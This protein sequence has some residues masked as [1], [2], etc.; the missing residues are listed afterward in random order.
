[1]AKS[2]SDTGIRNLK[3]RAK[4]YMVGDGA[5]LWLR[6]RTSGSK[7]FIVRKKTAGK[8]KNFT[9]GTWPDLSLLD[10]RRKALDPATTAPRQAVT[11]AELCDEFYDSEI[12]PKY[13]RPHHVRGYLDKLVDELGKRRLD[14][15]TTR[16]VSDF[17][18][19]YAKHGKV[20]ANRLL[21]IARQA[22]GYGVESGYIKVNP[23]DGL[24]RRVAGGEETTRARV[25]TDEEIRALWRVPSPHGPLLRFLTLTAARIGE[26]QLAAPA[27]VMGD[28]W[29]IPA[30]H[31]K[32]GRPHDVPLSAQAKAELATLP[33]D[34]RLLFG[35]TTTTG[36]QAWLRRWCEKK[37]I[38]PRFTPHDLRR[39]AATRMSKL[40]ILPHVIE[41]AL[42][43]TMQGVMGIYNRADFMEERKLALALWGAEAERI[44]N[45]AETEKI[46]PIKK[47]QTAPGGLS[48][49]SGATGE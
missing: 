40:G 21:A 37:G 17:L 9:L 20:A 13:R 1:M 7:T 29:R 22:L 46:T 33:A 23:A 4:D 2:L 16:E 28:L 12:A 47:I 35:L 48:R 30:E 14:E 43:H 34:R 36:V 26:A 5:G 18:K 41:K 27:S 38:E 44:A 32:N 49:H 6:V 3:P 31:S 11:L 8:A 25:L 24:T 45:S 42:N 15:L 39:T 10:A 19:A